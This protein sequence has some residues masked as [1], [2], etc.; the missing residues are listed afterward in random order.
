MCRISGNRD[1]RGATPVFW[2]LREASDR[3]GGVLTHESSVEQYDTAF[4]A[5]FLESSYECYCGVYGCSDEVR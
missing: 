5:T 3:I 1:V 4:L 2:P